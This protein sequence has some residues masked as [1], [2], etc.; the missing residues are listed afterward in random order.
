VQHHPR[1]AVLIEGLR[2]AGDEVTELNE[3]LRLDTAGRVAMMRQPWRLPVLAA[4]LV[5]CWMLLAVRSRRARRA[6]PDAV[7]V[8]YLGQFDIRLAHWLFRGMP[9]VLDH[10][11]SAS[12]IA[13]DRGLARSGGLKG[14]LMRAIDDGAVRR[15]DVVVVD[16]AE[17]AGAMPSPAAD[18]VVVAPVGA[19]QEW[20]EHGRPRAATPDGRPLRVIFVGLFTPLHGT[21]VI[22]EA[23][24]A[25]AGDDQIEV[26]MVGTG[27]DY[28]S[29]RQA[30]AANQHVTWIDWVPG[31]E[32]PGLVAAHDVSLGIFGTTTKALN[33]VPTKVFQGAAAGVALITSDTSPQRAALQDAALF[34]PPGDAEALAGALRRLAKDRGELAALQAAAYTRAVC[35]FTP[36]C[37][38]APVRERVGAITAPSRR[39]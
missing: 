3:P 8:G 11:A 24:A 13:S 37:V 2:A 38:V 33:V 22:G 35:A 34:V 31:A 12:G 4:K 19:A 1:V 30:T 29:C 39:G 10:L 16:T 5:R 26:T 21:H 25:L 15:A 20:F 17:Q 14:R 6:R 7:L 36:A 28:R 32:L 27:Q 18:R 9:L 23:L